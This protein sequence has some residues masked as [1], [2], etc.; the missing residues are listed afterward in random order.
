MIFF[1]HNDVV[2]LTFR[3]FVGKVCF[4]SKRLLLDKTNHSADLL[5]VS[6]VHTQRKRCV[7]SDNRGT[8]L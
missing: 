1:K 6:Q 5:I 2:C 8:N 3:R 7:I 4:F